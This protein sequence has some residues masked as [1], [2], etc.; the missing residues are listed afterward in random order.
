MT[1]NLPTKPTGMPSGAFKAYSNQHQH[2]AL[3]EGIGGSY[4]VIG[5]KGKTW[6]LRHQGQKY[7]FVRPD[8]GTQAGHLDVIILRSP[9]NKSKSFYDGYDE[10]T[11]GKRPLCA[12]LDGVIPDSDVVQRQAEACTLCPRNAWKTDANGRKSKDC[13]DYKRIAVLLCPDSRTN[14]VLQAALLEPVFLRIPAASLQNLANFGDEMERAGFPPYA[15]ITRVT[16]DPMA[17]HPKMVFRFRQALTDNEAP[18]VLPL[19][20]DDVSLRITGEDK[21]GQGP[22]LIPQQPAQPSPLFQ[23]AVQSVV[24]SFASA[25]VAPVQEPLFSAARV[26]E[27]ARPVVP[28]MSQQAD[29]VARGGTVNTAVEPAQFITPSPEGTKIVE[30]LDP[31]ES[32]AELDD[33]IN[34]VLSK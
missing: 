9:P 5:Y 24:G 23:Q 11:D 33:L 19:I 1:T 20:N 27:D 6:S 10:G 34:T 14:P 25:P 16:F 4:G 29:A 32:T 8:D 22:R 7:V 18:V 31:I 26:V 30:P 12:S 21:V 17:A 13:T 28:S 15:Y 3:G 2:S